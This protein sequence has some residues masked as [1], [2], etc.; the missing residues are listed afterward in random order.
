MR[1]QCREEPENYIN[2]SSDFSY[3]EEIPLYDKQLNPMDLAIDSKGNIYVVEQNGS[4]PTIQTSYFWKR[5]TDGV[6]HKF[7]TGILKG[8]YTEHIAVD[9]K[10]RVTV[11]FRNSGI[12]QFIPQ[13]ADWSTYN[14]EWIYNASYIEGMALDQTGNI[15]ACV[16]DGWSSK[17]YKSDYIPVPVSSVEI[18][19]TE[20]TMAKGESLKLNATVLPVVAEDTRVEWSSSNEAVAKVSATG[21]VTGVSYGTA[22]IT[23]KALG[24]GNQTTA[25]CTIRIVPAAGPRIE[26]FRTG[27]KTSYT[28]GEAVALAAR[29]GGGTAPYRYQFY[30]VRSNGSKV[31]LRN[32]A[33]SNTFSWNPVAPD[34]YKV[35]VS[36]KDA[37]GNAVSQ[38]KT[39]TVLAS[40]V[41]PLKIAVFRAGWSDTYKL[42]D[43]VNLAARGE[44]G[45]APYKYQFYVLRSN[46][47]R[48]NFRKTP[49]SSN[50]Y[51]WTPVTPDTYTLGVDV[52]DSTGKKV[53]QEKR[54]TVLKGA[55]SSLSVAVFRA[56]W[57]D[58]YRLGQT[59]HL[60]ARGAGGVAPYKYQF[61]VLRS[62]G[63]RVNFRRTP[64]Y[65]NVYPWTPVTPDT[66]ILGIDIYDSAGHKVTQKK[67]ITVLPK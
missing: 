44:G 50:I 11:N 62:N 56:G 12:V 5:T 23:A 39:V 14:C 4:S 53:N 46:G 58:T 7:S 66:Y 13:D 30:I 45:T 42:G 34:T 26:V 59:I 33:F 65:S 19:K 67:T 49:V 31:I 40:T 47:S 25:D 18:D 17:T 51:P 3:V 52:Y 1:S 48:V 15:Y 57:S 24:G 29:A 16:S 20:A 61:F 2:I 54:I 22:T 60:A 10:G 38:E 6:W 63:S 32:Y 28:V 36:V 55:G 41:E 21:T 35:G 27:N 43:T 37:A 64:V 8:T 9:H